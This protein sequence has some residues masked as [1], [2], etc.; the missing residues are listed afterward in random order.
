MR[1]FVGRPRHCIIK[2]GF[3]GTDEARRFPLDDADARRGEDGERRRFDWGEAGVCVVR[4][5]R[6]TRLCSWGERAHSVG[7]ASDGALSGVRRSHE[8]GGTT[9]DGAPTV[10]SSESEIVMV[11]ETAGC[12]SDTAGGVTSAVRGGFRERTTCTNNMP[13][14]HARTTW[15]QNGGRTTW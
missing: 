6:E 12:V 7:T 8:S 1:A 14:Q 2:A 11:A 9:S 5:C 4:D 10:S 13:E 15:S 3:D